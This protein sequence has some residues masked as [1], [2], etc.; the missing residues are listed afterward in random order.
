MV[1]GGWCVVC[2]VDG[3]CVGFITCALWKRNGEA[4]G[5]VVMRKRLV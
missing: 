5:S 1:D 2:M 3:G 4:A